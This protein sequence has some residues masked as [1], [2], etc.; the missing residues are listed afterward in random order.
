M[1]EL[2]KQQTVCQPARDQRK[3][4]EKVK[5]WVSCIILTISLETTRVTTFT[6]VDLAGSESLQ[7]EHPQET[8][9]IN[10]T[11]NGVMALPVSHHFI[12]S[13]TINTLDILHVGTETTG[14]TDKFIIQ[15]KMGEQ[16]FSYGRQ[17]WNDSDM[18]MYAISN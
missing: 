1:N 15:R 11:V 3:I 13:A 6:I 9:S 8:K 10:T 5:T 18:C 7:E 12:V 4:R 17:R 14:T 2:F 16:Y